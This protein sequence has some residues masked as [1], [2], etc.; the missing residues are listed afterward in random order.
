MTTG[1]ASCGL[2]AAPRL[3]PSPGV[4]WSDVFLFPLLTAL[5]LEGRTKSQRQR[6][7]LPRGRDLPRLCY[8][9]PWYSA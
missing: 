4:L 9:L 7:D 6:R 5:A 3:S 2:L 8:L 1:G